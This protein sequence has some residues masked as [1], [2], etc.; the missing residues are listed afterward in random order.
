[1]KIIITVED[2]SAEVL[3]F[4]SGIAGRDSARGGIKKV[5]AEYVVSVKNPVEDAPAAEMPVPEEEDH[6]TAETITA[7]EEPRQ[8]T[9]TPEISQGPP[10]LAELAAAM[11]AKSKRTA[12]LGLENGTAGKGTKV[13][14]EEG[15]VGIVAATWR[16]KALVEFTDGRGELLEA[17]D[18]ALADDRTSGKE[19]EAIDRETELRSLGSE[20]I[21]KHGSGAVTSV[22]KEFG[23]RNVS[24]LRPDQYDA[25]EDALRRVLEDA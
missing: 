25:V 11:D 22:L 1:M 24:G 18:I 5:E 12:Q 21:S 20:I 23:V 2:P 10:T 15:E 13:V 4:L 14:T 9:V 19:N 16:G 8:Q 7:P 6:G 17:K 3:G